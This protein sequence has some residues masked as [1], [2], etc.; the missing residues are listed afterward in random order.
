MHRLRS[1]LRGWALW[2]TPRPSQILIMVVNALA[3]AVAAVTVVLVPVSIGQNDLVRFGVLAGC[4]WAAT[5][6]TRHVEQ[7]RAVAHSPAVAHIDSAAV[8]VM[9]TTIVLPPAL[10]LSMVVLTNVLLWD[11]VKRRRTPPY[12]AVYTTSTILLGTSLAVLILATGLN[13]YP[14]LPATA[15]EFGVIALA[16]AV[17]WAV[18]FGLIVAAIASH[19]PTTS[20][21]ELFSDLS[22]QILEAG[23]AALGV[24]V[25]ITIVTT[26]VALPAVLVV[27]VALHRGSLVTGLE[28]AASID[29]KTGLAT[30][31]RWHHHAEQLLV[32]AQEAGTGLGLLMIDLD[33]FK[34]INDTYGHLFGDRVLRAVADE[35]RGEVRELDACGRWGG[36]EFAIVVAD[37]DSDQSLRRIAER[38]RLR[39]Q[40]IV[41]DAPVGEATE[42]VTITASVG[43][44][45]H[46]PDASTT[47]DDLVAAADSALYEAKRDRNTVRV[48]LT[49][50]PLPIALAP[51]RAEAPD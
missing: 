16:A 50:P 21:R 1:W 2:R 6:L 30:S 32:R 26:P 22:G 19:N 9:A 34:K 31:A 39:I 29:A 47:V 18:N 40:G 41:L 3:V 11:R 7:R 37:I 17:A 5:E 10:A 12:R 20:A 14:G 51:E 46:V 24:L 35:L 13:G 25:A 4:A 36:E 38:V 33:H 45:H 42:T 27:I 15:V 28:K 48:H 8:W 49:A 43:G 23:A 44:V